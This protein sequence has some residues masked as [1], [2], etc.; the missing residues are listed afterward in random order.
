MSPFSIVCCYFIVTV[1]LAMA[2]YRCVCSRSWFSY[3]V[4]SRYNIVK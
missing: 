4:F 1:R 2:C 3:Q